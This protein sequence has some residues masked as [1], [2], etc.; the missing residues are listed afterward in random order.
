MSDL[1][2]YVKGYVQDEDA[3]DEAVGKIIMIV[4]TIG[5]CMALGWWIW[6]MLKKKTDKSSC[7]NSDS[8]WCVE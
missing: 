1:T 6:N 4:I 8:P 7:T 2:K 3:V 5:C